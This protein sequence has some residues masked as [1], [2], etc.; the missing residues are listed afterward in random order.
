[1]VVVGI[2]R[3]LRNID[4]STTS[5]ARTSPGSDTVSLRTRTTFSPAGAPRQ[6]APALEA[7]I[8]PQG[9]EQEA[10]SP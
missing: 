10:T 3:C 1:M 6:L 8:F 5:F 2:Q 9:D 7:V 4:K